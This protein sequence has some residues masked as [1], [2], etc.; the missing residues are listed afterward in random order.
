[1]EEKKN[2]SDLHSDLASTIS[3]QL[4]LIDL[5][6]FR[7]VCHY[8]R[9]S[10]SHASAEIESSIPKPWFLL[11]GEAAQCSLLT[12]NDRIYKIEI[13]E[14][15]ESTCLASFVGWLLL[16]CKNDDSL[17]FFCPFSRARIEIP[18]CPLTSEQSESE[19]DHLFA[20][21]SSYPTNPDC[22]VV[23][24]K[25]K[26][27]ETLKLCRLRRGE[28]EW[29]FH[30]HICPIAFLDRIK[31]SALYKRAFHFL[32]ESSR[33]LVSF[34]YDTMKW[35]NYMLSP[36]R[37]PK[38]DTAEKL[39]YWVDKNWAKKESFSSMSDKMKNLLGIEDPCSISICGAMILRGDANDRV[40]PHEVLEDD[41]YKES[42]LRRELKGVWLQPRFH[43]ISQDQ[44]W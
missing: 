33:V 39:D 41:Q 26:D 4:G 44:R 7:G 32:A 35:L 14:M 25:R 15:A 21:F 40:I 16:Y 42:M 36:T 34:E 5:L 11:Y 31:S 24:I 38:I 30:E 8:W 29:T 17:F 6:S 43:Q 9:S 1:M 10:S 18:R 13:P 27:K 2:W 37:N 19:S 28:S 20:A 22:T 23:A 3:E 12:N